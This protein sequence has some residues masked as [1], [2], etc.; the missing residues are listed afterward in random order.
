MAIHR[1]ILFIVGIPL[2]LYSFHFG[3]KNIYKLYA[4]KSKEFPY[5]HNEFPLCQEVSYKMGIL[6]NSL[7]IK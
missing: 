1:K 5:N 2:P 3:Y 6:C 7:F 4:T